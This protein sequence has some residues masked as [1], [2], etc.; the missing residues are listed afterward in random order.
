MIFHLNT[1]KVPFCGIDLVFEPLLLKIVWWIV[2]ED[3][4]G[5]VVGVGGVR[6]GGGWV[7]EE[8]QKMFQ[9][10]V[11][12]ASI[13][14]V[15]LVSCCGSF[16]VLFSWLI[17]LVFCVVKWP[18]C[19]VCVMRTSCASWILVPSGFNKSV[20]Q[21]LWKLLCLH[22]QGSMLWLIRF[23]HDK[24]HAWNPGENIHIVNM[25]IIIWKIAKRIL[26]PVFIIKIINSF[27]Y[28][29]ARLVFYIVA[30]DTETWIQD[31]HVVAHGSL[32]LL[33]PQHMENYR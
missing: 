30:L 19:F 1:P 4:R 8:K 5:G 16:F 33:E 28:V 24:I 3:E 17:G 11:R 13:L 15:A 32:I 22:F 7:G 6:G 27:S 14:W 20:T 9:V 26:F 12:T 31:F 10:N 29:V 21:V 23:L 18:H 25:S 2:G